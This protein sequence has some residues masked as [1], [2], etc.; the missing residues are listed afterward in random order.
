MALMRRKPVRE[1]GSWFWHYGQAIWVPADPASD[2]KPP[3]PQELGCLFAVDAYGRRSK[4]GQRVEVKSIE[5]R[6]IDATNGL[7]MEF[8]RIAAVLEKLV[9]EK[10]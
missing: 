8:A 6:K 9:E 5:E 1:Q 3:V 10:S 2:Y 4:V 7:R